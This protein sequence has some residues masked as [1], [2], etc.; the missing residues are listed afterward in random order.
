M[1]AVSNTPI[2]AGD[3]TADNGTKTLLF[4]KTPVMSTYLLAFVIGDLTHIEKGGGRRDGGRRMDDARQGGTGPVCAGH[5][6][7]A[8]VLLQRL[9]RHSVSRCLSS[10]TWRSPTS[11]P[12]AMEN[13]GCV[14]YRETALLVDPANSSAGTRQ[15]VAEVVAH[16]MAHM[17][18]GDLV[19]MDW[20]DDLWLNESF[21]T[22]VGTKAVDW[23]FPE[24][25]MW[26]Q[27]VNMDT[28]RAFNLDGSEEL[29]SHRAGGGQSGGGE[30]AIRRHQ[31]QQGRFGAADA[32]TL[33]DAQRVPHWIERLSEH[34]TPIRT[35]A[36]PTC[37][38]RWKSPRASR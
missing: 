31:L 17:W 28:N 25:S 12:G 1:Q 3:A 18:F 20:W 15:R 26:T 24:W 6:G 11:R 14:T 23:L 7:Q 13:W 9:F 16:E 8:A 2:I 5:V 32:G 10:T 36:P 33:P 38:P 35:R 30:P 29:P 21:A 27:F 22:W 37:G 19:T 4:D 34:G